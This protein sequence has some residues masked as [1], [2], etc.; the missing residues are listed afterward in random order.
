[1][2]H[3]WN[4]A[5]VGKY[6]YLIVSRYTFIYT[7]EYFHTDIWL[8]HIQHS[9]LYVLAQWYDDTNTHT[10]YIPATVLSV[11]QPN[12]FKPERFKIIHSMFQTINLKNNTFF[13]NKW[14]FCKM[15]CEFVYIWKTLIWC[16]LLAF[17]YFFNALRS[18][19]LRWHLSYSYYFMSDFLMILRR[20][21]LI[22][23]VD[24]IIL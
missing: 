19:Y 6:A 8:H 10:L 14:T 18:W 4:Q 13:E 24:L 20:F 3:N 5:Q 11:A 17:I 9:S 7:T 22:W 1:M 15:E 23:L 21:V 2:V 16:D 12:V